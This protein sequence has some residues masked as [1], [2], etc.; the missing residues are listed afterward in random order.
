MA[1]IFKKEVREGE[2]KNPKTKIGPLSILTM[3]V[4]LMMETLEC[5]EKRWETRVETH[6]RVNW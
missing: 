1:Y 5:I 4:K 3:T 2:K 6:A